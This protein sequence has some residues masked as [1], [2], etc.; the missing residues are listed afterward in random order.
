MGEDAE[1]FSLFL[2]RALLYLSLF[3]YVLSLFVLPFTP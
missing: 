2:S 1:H 3:S